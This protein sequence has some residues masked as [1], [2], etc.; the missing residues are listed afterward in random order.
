MSFLATFFVEK[1]MF[2]SFFFKFKFWD[3]GI[4]YNVLFGAKP[5]VL[6]IYTFSK[7]S[8]REINIFNRTKFYL[9]ELMEIFY[10]LDKK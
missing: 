7:I 3:K 1:T 10:F 5:K 8:L 4:Q 6:F 2:L 9:I